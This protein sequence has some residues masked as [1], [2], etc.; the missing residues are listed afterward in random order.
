[1]P[2]K[3]YTAAH[4]SAA[5]FRRQPAQPKG[6]LTI[7]SAS[8]QNT[9]PANHIH[10]RGC[11]C[12]FPMR[13]PPMLTQVASDLHNS[14]CRSRAAMQLRHTLLAPASSDGIRLAVGDSVL[15]VCYAP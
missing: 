2:G 11:F 15:L 7:T 8:P 1:M 10:K 5:L 3:S 6:R 4:Q 14:C 9:I 13:G 12:Q